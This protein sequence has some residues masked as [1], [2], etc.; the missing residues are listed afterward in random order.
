MVEVI[1]HVAASL[2]GYIATSDEHVD[3]LE[4]F[5]S[6]GDDHGVGEPAFVDMGCGPRVR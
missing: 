2:D 3:W 1:Y 6:A 5:N 4:R